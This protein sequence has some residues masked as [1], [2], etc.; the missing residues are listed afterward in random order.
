MSESRGENAGG[1]GGP[2]EVL[3]LRQCPRCH[4]SFAQTSSFFDHMRFE[5]LDKMGITEEEFRRQFKAKQVGLMNRIGSY[6]I[7]KSTTTLI[8]QKREHYKGAGR[9]KKRASMRAA[10][11][12]NLYLLSPSSLKYIPVAARRMEQTVEDTLLS[13][14]EAVW[15]DS[16]VVCHCCNVYTTLSNA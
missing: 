12:K 1:G 4:S 2:K 14:E 11:S 8:F 3:G 6:K 13:F 10:V 9:E 16:L 7:F 5:C 15:W